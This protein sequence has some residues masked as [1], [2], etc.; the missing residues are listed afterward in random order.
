MS[1]QQ[2]LWAKGATEGLVGEVVVAS[3]PRR[4]L[5][6][7]KLG[8]FLARAWRAVAR[9]AVWL[10]LMR[11]LVVPLPERLLAVQWAQSVAV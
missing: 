8:T 5:P 3:R 10:L 1:I 6:R 4:C 2:G 7:N 9:L 11:P